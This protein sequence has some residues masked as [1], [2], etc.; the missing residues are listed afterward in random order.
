VLGRQAVVHGH[1]GAARARREL[2]EELVVAAP[3]RGPDA[4]PA[5]VEVHHDGAPGS[6]PRRRRR[7]QPRP[8]PR[9]G[10][11]HHV[12][13][14]DAARRV[15]GRRA[16]PRAGHGWDRREPLHVSVLVDADQAVDLLD[17]GA[18][19]AVLR[20][21][22]CRLLAE[23][24]PGLADDVQCPHPPPPHAKLPA[25]SRS[26]AAR[27]AGGETRQPASCFGRAM[28]HVPGPGERAQL[29]SRVTVLA[30]GA[31]GRRRGFL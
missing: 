2:G 11:H 28:C 9:R 3:G 13:R 7:V 16:A 29:C 21:D 8:H 19:A 31:L 14:D 15:R 5:A 1:H 12:P 6:V 25:F 23:A 10:V 20:D 17:D 26:R 4:E 27:Q 22:C 18:V 30:W 24:D